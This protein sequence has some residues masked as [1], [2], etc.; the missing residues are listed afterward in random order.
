MSDKEFWLLV[1]SAL[2]AF[3][4]A[5]EQKYGL[6]RTSEMRHIFKDYRTE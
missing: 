2:L 3:I 1:R 5:I 6:P 4:D